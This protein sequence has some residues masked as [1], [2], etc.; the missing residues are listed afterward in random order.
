MAAT[1]FA[2]EHIKSF[3]CWHISLVH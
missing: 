2:A 1:T 3:T